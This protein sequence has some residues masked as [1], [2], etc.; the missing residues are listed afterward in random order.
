MEL[1]GEKIVLDTKWKILKSG[2]PSMEDLKQMYIYC[3]YFKA[4]KGVL[5]FPSANPE[6]DQP[7][8]TPF[9]DT[10]SEINCQVQF[11][12]VINQEGQLKRNLGLQIL[13]QV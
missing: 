7:K 6:I 12:N 4:S 2:S 11:I 1:H 10:I 8:A 5:L 13:R 9:L 3:R